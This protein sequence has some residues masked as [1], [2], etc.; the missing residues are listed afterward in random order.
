MA[1]LTLIM[2]DLFVHMC[3][4]NVYWYL[5]VASIEL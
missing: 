3:V 1:M 5:R 4:Y 2:F